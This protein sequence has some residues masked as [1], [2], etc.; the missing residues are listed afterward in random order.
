VAELQKRSDET[1]RVVNAR[2]V[3]PEQVV[4]SILRATARDLIAVIEQQALAE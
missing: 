2:Q 1:V 3:D 4:A